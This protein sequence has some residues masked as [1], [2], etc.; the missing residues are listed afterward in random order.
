MGVIPPLQRYL[1]RVLRVLGGISHWAA[2][3]VLLLAQ[4]PYASKV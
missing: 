4:E 3:C 1:E 2:K